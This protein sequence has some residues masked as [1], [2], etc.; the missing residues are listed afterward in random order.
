MTI[1]T[2]RQGFLDLP[3][4]S[5]TAFVRDEARHSPSHHADSVSSSRNARNYRDLE[6]VSG[7]CNASRSIEQARMENRQPQPPPLALGL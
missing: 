5:S 3:D 1:T 4:R 2:A 6:S 7:V